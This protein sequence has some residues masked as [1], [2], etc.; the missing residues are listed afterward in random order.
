MSKENPWFACPA[1]DLT[2]KAKP[3]KKVQVTY[4][5]SYSYN[6]GIVENGEWFAGY[7]VPPPIVPEGYELIDRGIGLEM[8]AHPPFATA[9]LSHMTAERVVQKA[10]DEQCLLRESNERLAKQR[11]TCLAEMA[12]WATK[13]EVVQES[14]S[15]KA[16]MVGLDTTSWTHHTS[17][18]DAEDHLI[19]FYFGD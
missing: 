10:A 19:D 18:A 1:T 8:N 11:A 15:W 13:P 3:G 14:S 16:R 9:L 4:A 12:N 2:K 17:K 6:G 7:K 5:V